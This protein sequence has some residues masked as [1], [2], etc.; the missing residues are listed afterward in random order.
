[1]PQPDFRQQRSIARLSSLPPGEAAWFWITQDGPGRAPLLHLRSSRDDPEARRFEGELAPLRRQSCGPERL[2]RLH[3][4]EEG[5]LLAT[6]EGPPRLPVQLFGA[7]F[8]AHRPARL[9]GRTLTLASVDGGRYRALRVLRLADHHV[10]S[11][12]IEAIEEG[13][14]LALWLGRTPSSGVQLEV[15]PT[16]RALQARVPEGGEGLVQGALLGGAE[17]TL[18]LQLRAPLEVEAREA[19]LAWTRLHQL[20]P[21]VRRL[22]QAALALGDR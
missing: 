20:W 19:L 4:D 15:A 22:H 21:G 10:L 3:R 5:A 6:F 14:R 18:R 7:W 2:G 12:A 16:P 1:M 11:E 9:L 13:G 8:R 17:G